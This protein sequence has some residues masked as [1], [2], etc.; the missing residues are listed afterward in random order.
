MILMHWSD[1]HTIPMKNVCD[2]YC[3]YIAYWKSIQ[4]CKL[5]FYVKYLWC[6]YKQIEGDMPAG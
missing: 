3:T 2:G 6:D 4:A 1:K 5:R